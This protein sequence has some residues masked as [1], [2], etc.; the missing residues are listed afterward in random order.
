MSLT[1]KDPVLSAARFMV[2]AAIA[3]CIT[4]ALAIV[5]VI[6]VILFNQDRVLIEVAR[7][8]APSEILG[9]VILVM[10][11]AAACLSLGAVFFRHLYRLIGTVGEG[12]PFTPVNAARLR[13]MAWIAVA[14]N[15]ITVPLALLGTYLDEVSGKVHVNADI[16]IGGILLA[17][18]LF[19]LARVFRKGTEMRADLEG[20]V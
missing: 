10:V 6:P 13:A 20:M 9:A 15:A 1:P 2:G 19:I 16:S 14:V 17:L 18:I 11:M 4:V 7:P 5:V 8:G 12:D 3:L